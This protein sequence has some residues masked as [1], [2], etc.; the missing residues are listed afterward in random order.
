MDND[1]AMHLL[2]DNPEAYHL[3]RKELF[4]AFPDPNQ[5]LTHADVKNLPYLNATIWET[6]RVRP[7]GGASQRTIPEGGAVICGHHFPEGVS[8]S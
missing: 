2:N 8:H 3:L 1:R 5:K 7:V 4:A 6:L